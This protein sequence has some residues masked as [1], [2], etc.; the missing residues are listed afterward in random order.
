[1]FTGYA[2][3]KTLQLKGETD[4][5]NQRDGT[6]DSTA[7][8]PGDPGQRWAGGPGGSGGSPLEVGSPGGHLS[9]PRVRTERRS[10]YLSVV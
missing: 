7:G 6:P 8:G 2:E 9:P 3:V 4:P 5:R 10:V 1:M